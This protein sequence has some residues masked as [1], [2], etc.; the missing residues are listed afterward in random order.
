MRESEVGSYRRRL[1]S[2]AEPEINVVAMIERFQ[3]DRARGVSTRLTLQ[4]SSQ[5]VSERVFI[6]CLKKRLYKME[7][8]AYIEELN[9]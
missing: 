5:Y 1:C 3:C 6:Q 4:L 9:N 2:V 8:S 7:S